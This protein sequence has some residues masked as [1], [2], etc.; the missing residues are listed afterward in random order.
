MFE[1][2]VVY[3]TDNERYTDIAILSVFFTLISVVLVNNLV[4]FRVDGQELA[5]VMVVLITSLAVAYPFVHYLL[6]REQEEVKEQWAEPRM[7]RRHAEEFALYISFFLGCTVAF[8]ISTF[9][10]PDGFYDIQVQ[11]LDS[12]GAPIMTGQVIDS[13]F[14]MEIIINNLWVFL[15]TFILTFFVTS[16]VVFILVWNASVL[17]V[18]IGNLSQSLFEVPLR[19]LPYLPHGIP[20]IGAYVL[21]GIAGALMSYEAEL[22]LFGEADKDHDYVLAKDALILLVIGIVAIFVAGVIEVL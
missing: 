16:G 7:L 8:A 13:T 10:V 11:V 5:G 4:P 12:I 9:Y 17:G 2:V 21:A 22:Y 15:V 1:R 14:L 20:E 19:T 18:L 3:F 6:R